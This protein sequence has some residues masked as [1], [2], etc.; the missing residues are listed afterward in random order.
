MKLK[1]IFN[2]YF[3]LSLASYLS[4]YSSQPY[5]LIFNKNSF[6]CLIYKYVKLVV[7]SFLESK[8]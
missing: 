2:T 6:L 4:T 8:Q 7:N 1:T 5:C 3:N